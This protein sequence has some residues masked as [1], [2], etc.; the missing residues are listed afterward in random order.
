MKHVFNIVLKL[1]NNI[2]KNYKI[3]F[4][5]K[6]WG[7]NQWFCSRKESSKSLKKSFLK[8]NLPAHFCGYD[9]QNPVRNW[10]FLN[11]WFSRYLSFGEFKVPKIALHN[12]IINKTWQIKNEENSAHGF[13][14][15][16]LT[17]HL[18]KFL[19]DR[20]KPWRVGALRVCTGYNFFKRKSLVRAV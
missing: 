15:N 1:N 5:S 19:K 11:K 12:K 16:Y 13:G 17:N 3:I 7:R 2:W 8:K 4:C 14:D 18:I 20:I 9:L 6:K 10:F